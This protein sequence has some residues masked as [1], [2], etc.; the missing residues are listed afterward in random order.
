MRIFINAGHHNLDSGVIVG[1]LREND[2]AKEIRDHL[3]DL[4]KDRE[5]TYIPDNLTLRE[6]IDSVNLGTATEWVLGQ[7]TEKDFALDIHLNANNNSQL[8]GTEGYYSTDSKYAEVFSL[9]VAEKLL[10]PNRGA[11][12]DSTAYVGSLGWLRQLPCPAVVLEVC[13]LTNAEDKQMLMIGQGRR[14]AAEGIKNALDELFP[15]PVVSIPEKEVLSVLK[16]FINELNYLMERLRALLRQDRTF[17][18]KRSPKWNYKKKEFEQSNPK[19]CAVCGHT[20]VAL[21]HILPFHIDSSVELEDNNLIWLCEG[22][23]T[24]NHHFEFGHL[25]NWKSWNEEVKLDAE[26]WR[27]KIQHRP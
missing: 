6:S 25:Q 8:R 2:L 15:Q 13:Y 23:M 21:H 5:V 14:L 10:I 4:L 9:K 27:L 17:G 7:A 26:I 19:Q 24:R 12:H 16:A 20:K 18:A 1:N 11:K 3:K 22:F